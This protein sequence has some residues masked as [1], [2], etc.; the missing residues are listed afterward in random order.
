MN[1]QITSKQL[2]ATYDA[3]VQPE[4]SAV[5]AMKVE[6]SAG[7]L[8]ISWAPSHAPMAASKP[9][10]YDIDDNLSDGRKLLVVVRSFD[11]DATIADVSPDVKATVTVA[12]V[13]SDETQG[14]ER[15][16]TLEPGDS[17]QAT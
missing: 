2:V 3:P 5:P 13:R 4:P 14:R 17:S 11:H 10:V 16:V 15:T 7:G 12:A 8:R 6:R 9:M 1:G